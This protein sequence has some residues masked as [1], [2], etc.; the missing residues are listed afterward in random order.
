MSFD[1]LASRYLDGESSEAEEREL[2]EL[3]K[4][5]PAARAEFARWVNQH[6]ALRWQFSEPRPAAARRRRRPTQRNSHSFSLPIG[7][8]AAAALFLVV[9]AWGSRPKPLPR[10]LVERVERDKTDRL[11][12]PAPEEPAP[13]PEPLPPEPAPP[14]AK[15]SPSF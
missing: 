5:D 11:L 9:L 2:L 15:P 8:A 13:R 10:P 7:A 1:E 3:L 12:R 4:G 14:N 6:A